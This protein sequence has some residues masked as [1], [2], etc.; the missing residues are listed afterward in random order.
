MSI[1]RILIESKIESKNARLAGRLAMN[2]ASPLLLTFTLVGSTVAQGT[3]PTGT[4]LD[5]SGILGT[6]QQGLFGI[7]NSQQLVGTVPG[8]VCLEVLRGNGTRLGYVLSHGSVITDSLSLTV[9]GRHLI[10]N[11]DFWLDAASGTIYFADSIHSGSGISAYYHYLEGKDAPASS[12]AGSGIMLN[13]GSSAHVGLLY[14]QTVNN[15]LGLNTS[16]NGL[17]LNS[18][19]G[20]SKKSSFNSMAYFSDAQRSD[21]LVMNLQARS[22]NPAPSNPT[23]TGKGRL[24]VQDLALQQGGLRFTANLSDVGKKFTGFQSL[25]LGAASDKA[26]LD[27]LTMLEGEKGIKR[28][29]FGIGI[30]SSAKA[31]PASGLTFN[32]QQIQDGKDAISQQSAGFNSGLVHAHYGQRT[33]G[34]KFALFGGLRE[35]DK[36]QWQKEKGLITTDMG[37]GFDF[38]AGKPGGISYS[39]LR[40]ADG[41]RPDSPIANPNAPIAKP[42]DSA[43]SAVRAQQPGM[44]RSGLALQAGALEFAYTQR[45]TDRL[46][47]RLGDLSDADKNALALDIRR[48]F[49][50]NVKL[51]QITQPERDQAAREVGIT[52]SSISSRFALGKTGGFRFSELSIDKTADAPEDG[53]KPTVSTVAA[54]KPTGISRQSFRLDTPTL[55]FALVKQTIGE[56]FGRLGDLSDVEKH[57][58]ANEHG[59]S[60][61]QETL[62]WLFGKHGKFAVSRW[63]VSGSADAL[64]SAVAQAKKDGKDGKGISDALKLI[65]SGAERN[66]LSLELTGF[67]LVRNTAR[68]DKDFTRAADLALP[69][70]DRHAIEN[71][72]GFART[73]QTIHFEG[74]K[75]MSL[76]SF[77]YNAEDKLDKLKHETAKNSFNFSPTKLSNITYNFDK[78]IAASNGKASGTSHAL[79]TLMQKMSSGILFNFTRDDSTTLDKDKTS[80]RQQIEKMQIGTPLDKRGAVLDYETRQIDFEDGKYQNSTN[81]NLHAKPT[82]TLTF[83]YGKSELERTA[84]PTNKDE[85]GKSDVSEATESLDF[86]LQATRKFAVIFGTSQTETTDNQDRKTVSIGLKGEPFQNVTVAAKFD[87]AHDIGKNTRGVSDVSIGN[88]KPVN[89]GPLKELSIKAGYASLN[90]KRKLQNEAMTGHASW[91]LWK[92]EFLVDYN[93][94]TK[95]FGKSTIARLYSFKTDPNPKRWFHGSFLYKIR[96][97][98]TGKEKQIRRFTADALVSRTSHFVYTYGTLPEDDKGEMQPLTTGDVA[99]KQTL[100]SNLTGQF[101][102]RLSDN[103]G[104]KIMTRSLGLGLEGQLSHTSKITLELSRDANGFADRYD[105]SDRLRLA[106]DHQISADKFLSFS[107]EIRSHS[108]KGTDGQMLLDEVRATLDFSSR[109]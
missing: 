73:D 45:R 8:T 90:D 34:Q 10:Y 46:F 40:I 68:T 26:A 32:W 61:E 19:F 81:F 91:T 38:A 49:D 83:H 30:G 35:A 71:E 57:E 6:S 102:Y 62:D 17:S 3:N 24:L 1:N 65:G 89:I 108:G 63:K 103:T 14:G 48:Q 27:Q 18:T 5:K 56:T 20:S 109:F 44:Q 95:E 64:Q 107:T 67:K 105:R 92:S 101:Y 82:D 12:G 59:L 9:D 58:F 51:E 23:D 36:A 39:S 2:V 41:T 25:K 106:Y 55:Q 22:A 76:D 11:R 70:A 66:S 52:R 77:T 21:N 74:V 72:R 53:A 50:P 80:Q 98:V 79:L 69:E 42:T 60:R 75:G 7:G 96:T 87:E 47:T 28:L 33:V 88:A 16:I 86:E 54:Q 99:F 29:G 85:K 97:L 84:D 100:H 43:K 4:A 104:T 31:G 93:G 78:D 15:G 13:F 94:I 37:F